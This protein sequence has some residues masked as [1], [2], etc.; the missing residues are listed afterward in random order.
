MILWRLCRF[1]AGTTL[2][3]ATAWVVTVVV[4]WACGWFCDVVAHGISTAA[5]DHLWYGIAVLALCPPMAVLGARRPGTRVWTWFIVVPMLLV[6]GWPVG[7]I[8]LQGSELRGLQLETPQVVAFCLVLIMGVGNYCGTCYT[9]CALLYGVAVAMLVLNMSLVS[10]AWMLDRPTVRILSTVTMVV[11][12]FLIRSVGRATV[13][14]RFDRLW[15]DFF[16]AFGI[17]WGRR[18]QDR[19]N[20]LAQNERLPIRLELDGFAWRSDGVPTSMDSLSTSCSSQPA[21]SVHLAGNDQEVE[22]RLEHI[23]RWLLRRFVDPSWID[24]R[25]GSNSDEAIKQMPVDS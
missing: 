5:A 25:L 19:V 17:V 11:T 21:Q 15:F 1:A 8:W 20:H 12:V 13:E 14:S 10:P 18:I 7:T 2:R 6:L 23:L 16:D 3:S 9:F 4:T 24:G 22:A